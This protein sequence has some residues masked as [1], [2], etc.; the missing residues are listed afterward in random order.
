MT[1]LSS[2]RAPG[3]NAL[4]FLREWTALAKEDQVS[5][6]TGL[7][8]TALSGDISDPDLDLSHT[9]QRDSR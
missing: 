5:A 2:A 1:L 4:S 3:L 6:S 8:A 7:D 9:L